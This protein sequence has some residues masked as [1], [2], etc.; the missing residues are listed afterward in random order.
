[1]RIVGID[2]GTTHCAV[3]SV[4]PSRGPG[5]PVEDVPIPQLVR[6]GE[7]APR[8]LLPSTVYVPAGA[9]LTPE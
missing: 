4:D 9:E 2:L 3:A 8:A 6:L 1:M 7:V 5:A